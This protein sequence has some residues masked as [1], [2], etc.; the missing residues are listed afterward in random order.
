MYDVVIVGAGA[1]GL[2]AAIYAVRRNL[3]TLVISKDVGGQIL[4][5]NEIENYPGFNSITGFDLIEKMKK[6]AEG[7]GVEIREAEV[8]RI[9]RVADGSFNVFTG[10]DS[11]QSE[12]LIITIGLS[13]RR[14]AV[15]G[16][17]EL[18]GRGVT[19][20]ATCDGPFF[21]NKSVA[22]IG[23]GNSALDAAELMSKIASQVYLVHRSAEFKAFESLVQEV[24][25]RKNIEII[26]NAQI[27]EIGGDN[28]VERLV[29]SDIKTKQDR[30]LE[31]Q[32][33]FVE[34]GRIASTDL[35]ADFVVRD[36]QNKIEINERCE[37]NTPGI[38][39]AG[40]VTNNEFK[41]I[42][43]AT[44][45]GT[46]A[47]LAAYQYLQ[48]KKGLSTEIGQDYSTNLKH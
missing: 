29:V 41:Q 33:V 20:C 40:D 48:R 2:T 5:T 12:S 25:N 47:A 16:E 35:V 26:L 37:T 11:F 19:Y 43:V 38:F 23:G 13:P 3:K 31:V 15:P 24:K 28:K 10:R 18:S 39:A 34:I 1:A 30:I 44:G 42:T 7:L 27:K 17:L 21:K 4:W 36:N 9:E 32:G 46:I 6:Q 14:L 22:V 45:Q 8:K